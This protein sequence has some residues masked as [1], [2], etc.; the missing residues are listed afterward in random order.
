MNQNTKDIL[1][2]WGINILIS[3]VGYV[4]LDYYEDSKIFFLAMTALGGTFFIM[5]EIKRNRLK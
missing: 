4:I 3:F 2:F 5:R 1:L